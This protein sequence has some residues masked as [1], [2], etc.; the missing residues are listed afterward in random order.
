M[1]SLTGFYPAT[2]EVPDKHPQIAARVV[3]LL[4][5]FVTT[6]DEGF[7]QIYGAFRFFREE[8]LDLLRNLFE[9]RDE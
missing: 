8:L 9:F 6:G 3:D 5:L 7:V 4:C 1:C 2:K